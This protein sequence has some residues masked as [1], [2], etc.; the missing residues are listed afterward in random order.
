[1]HLVFIGVTDFC[2]NY[3][4]AGETVVEDLELRCSCRSELWASHA[5]VWLGLVQE[6]ETDCKDFSNDFWLRN[7]VGLL[8]RCA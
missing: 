5:P 3:R 1:M 2:F 8:I 4:C 6:E 7:G